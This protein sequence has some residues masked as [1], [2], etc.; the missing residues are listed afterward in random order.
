MPVFGFEHE[1]FAI[2]SKSAGRLE[3]RKILCLNV[4]LALAHH[5]R[6]GERADLNGIVLDGNWTV[7]L[8]AAAGA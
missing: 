1:H 6:R 5:A 8:V 3:R 4:G 7:E 2:E